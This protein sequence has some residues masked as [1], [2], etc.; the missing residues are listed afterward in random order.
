[1]RLSQLTRLQ[2][3]TE[4]ILS[5]AK[6]ELSS[7]LLSSGTV[8]FL[9][10]FHPKQEEATPKKTVDETVVIAPSITNTQKKSL[11]PDFASFSINTVHAVGSIDCRRATIGM[12]LTTTSKR[13]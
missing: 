12:A 2:Q 1:M 11:A 3:R 10:S 8:R 13:V 5:S 4:K 9:Y 6:D 7:C